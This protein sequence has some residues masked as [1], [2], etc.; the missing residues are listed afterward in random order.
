[1][2]LIEQSQK[3]KI[4]DQ[5]TNQINQELV[6]L[7][8]G[9]EMQALQTTVIFNQV[10]YKV[11]NKVD[12]VIQVQAVFPLILKEVVTLARVVSEI[13]LPMG[14]NQ[15]TVDQVHTI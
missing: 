8:K 5:H 7:L 3:H 2:E 11:V 1:M 9:T 4:I 14:I 12:Q 6:H 10:V 15:D 13:K